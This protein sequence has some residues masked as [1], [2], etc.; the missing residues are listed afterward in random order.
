MPACCPATMIRGKLFGPFNQLTTG[1]DL[2]DVGRYEYR[3][4]IG[5]NG[6][7]ND[8]LAIEIAKACIDLDLDDSVS[9]TSEPRPVGPPSFTDLV[10][11][12]R[13]DGKLKASSSI[14]D[15]VTLNKS[16]RSLS[17]APSTP[18]RTPR[19][20][21]KTQSSPSINDLMPLNK[22]QRKRM[23]SCSS[24]NDLMA[25]NLSDNKMKSSTSITDLMT[26]NNLGNSKTKIDTDFK[27]PRKISRSNSDLGALE[28]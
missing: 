18:N 14:A 6:E 10:S 22:S 15:L 21:Q 9:E 8:I 12:N 24:I 11:L 27:A 5:G 3:H 1:F 26:L 19:R 17:T 20:R 2:N 13:T 4:T 23:Q 25:L 28:W 16:D 7:K